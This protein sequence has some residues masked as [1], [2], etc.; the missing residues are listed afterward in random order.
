MIDAD[1]NGKLRADGSNAHERSEDLLTSTVFGLLRYL[2]AQD[3][4]VPLLRR[5]LHVQLHGS[6]LVLTDNM[7]AELPRIML[8]EAVTCDVAFWPS[9]GLLGQPDVLLTFLDSV[10]YPLHYVVIEAK[11][12]SP[13]SGEANVAEI[14]DSATAAIDSGKSPQSP[15]QLARYW[16]G[17]LMKH[18]ET[19]LNRLSLVYLT[20]HSTPPT[21]ELCASLRACPT[22]NLGWLAWSDIWRVTAPL[23]RQPNPSLAAIDITRLLERRGMKALDAFKYKAPLV[24]GRGRFWQTG[25]WFERIPLPAI[26]ALTHFWRRN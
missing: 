11:L 5:A 8:D 1:V 10:G 19:E 14:L 13:K 2:P 21:D 25:N 4:F 12:H 15:D 20:A 17:L 26:P 23:A 16:R 24:V 3:A 18:P 6:E 22:M 9:F 7:H